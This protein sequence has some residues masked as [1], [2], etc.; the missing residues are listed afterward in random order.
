MT[1]YEGYI[2]LRHGIVSVIQDPTDRQIRLS[3]A[4]TSPGHGSGNVSVWLDRDHATDMVAAL[5][6]AVEQLDATRLA[7]RNGK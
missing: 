6:M 3:V 2:D 1:G 7:E 4:V 5:T